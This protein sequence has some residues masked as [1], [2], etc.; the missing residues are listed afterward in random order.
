[1]KVFGIGCIYFGYLNDDV[2]FDISHPKEYLEDISNRLE[3]VE[4]IS[5]INVYGGTQFSN[6]AVV[7]ERGNDTLIPL[8]QGWRVEFDLYLPFRVQESIYARSDVEAVHVD[9]LFGYEMPV[10]ICSYEWPDEEG[11]A[12]PSSS[13]VV[14]RKYLQKKLSDLNFVCNCVGPSPFHANFVL[15]ET[16]FE[17]RFGID[18]VTDNRLGYASIELVAP[19]ETDLIDAFEKTNLDSIFS[20]YYSLSNL[21][22]KVL[23]SQTLIANSA[24]NLLEE[25][26]QS[27]KLKIFKSLKNHQVNID[28]LNREIFRETLL[29]LDMSNALAEADHNEISGDERPLDYFFSE[30]RVLASQENWSK[31]SEVAK[32]F[33]ERRQKI[34]GNATAIVSGIIGGLVG[35]TIGSLATYLLTSPPAAITPP[36]QPPTPTT[37]PDTAR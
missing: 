4:N 32:F 16:E 5:N 26:E 7:V 21:R 1:M 24:R 8:P 25:K 2:G 18:D 11:D 36:P 20:V 15:R 35:A 3:K 28:V 17:D 22:S 27:G 9:I 6:L 34:I 12:S 13:V 31:F 30:Y 14:V 23:N 37:A 10:A 33:E 29:R 19:K